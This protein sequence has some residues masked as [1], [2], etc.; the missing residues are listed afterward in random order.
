[1]QRF[2]PCA[3]V[4]SM[5]HISG[6]NDVRSTLRQQLRASREAIPAATRIA[7]AAAV[8]GHLLRLPAI[9]AANM[10]AGYWAVGGELPL[11]SLVTRLP[12]RTHFC[13]PVLQADRRLRFVPWR[14]GDG[15]VTNRYGIPEPADAAQ[16]LDPQSL[17]V[18]LLP[19]LG[20]TR[21]GDRLGTGGGWYDRSFAFRHQAPVPPL[22]IGVGFARQQIDGDAS[23][24]LD[25]REWDV[26]LDAV[27]TERELIVCSR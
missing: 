13:L 20:F 2:T 16:A 23:T 8:A 24:R 21:D 9:R 6:M 25:P 5:D 19:L 26:R 1:M 17:D 3:R 14:N 22:L 11:H 18:V 27:A 12:Q 10:I 4:P 7:A 15:V